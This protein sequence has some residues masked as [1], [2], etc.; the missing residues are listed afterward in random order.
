MEKI[1][2]VILHYCTLEATLKCVE[3]IIEKMDMPNYFIVIVDN[4]SPNETG[5]TL[6]NEYAQQNNIYV[7]RNE[8]N[9]GFA[10]GNNVGYHFAKNKGASYICMLNNDTCILSKDFGTKIQQVF[11]QYH[12]FVLGPDVITREE[13]NACSPIEPSVMTYEAIHKRRFSVLI[14]MILCSIGLDIVGRKIIRLFI[15]RKENQSYD[16]QRY[17]LNDI[18]LH[19][20][21]MIFSPLYIEKYEGLNEQT[22]LYMEEDILYYEMKRDGNL[23]LYCPDIHI[24]HDESNATDY[25]HIGRKRR[26][27]DM[28]NHYRSMKVIE[29]MLQ[30][31]GR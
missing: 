29:H 19:G 22:F 12:Y 20:C 4:A 10:R 15:P 21:F 26:M 25:A 3:S 6:Q 31:E 11:E 5:I 30:Q 17:Y 27:F 13:G 14:Q 2:F 24:Y 18:M 7:I 9:L 23:M 8:K 1:A 28:K 16:R